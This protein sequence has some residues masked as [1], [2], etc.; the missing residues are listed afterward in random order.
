MTTWDGPTYERLEKKRLDNE[1]TFPDDLRL[2]ARRCTSWLERAEREMRKECPDYDAAFI[3]C[4]IAFNAAYA[5]M[6]VAGKEQNGERDAFD[7]Y[8]DMIISLDINRTIY[9]AIWRKLREF[10]DAIKD[11]VS[12]KYVF[13]RFWDY[14]NVQPG[15]TGWKHQFKEDQKLVRRAFQGRHPRSTRDTKVVLSILFERL[16]VLRNQLIHGGATWE[17]S[18]NRA[19]V[20]D[21]ARIMAFLVPLFIELMMDNPDTPWPPPPFPRVEDSHE[22]R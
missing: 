8:F 20:T 7:K 3:F 11:L 17:G 15:H 12:N 5:E 4:W 18:L 21:G 6:R 14:H 16:Y 22:Q 19:Q 2:R 10:S 1:D 9:G 13:E